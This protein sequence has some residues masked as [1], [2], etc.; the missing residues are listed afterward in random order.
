[1]ELFPPNKTSL[2]LPQAEISYIPNFLSK[3][4][5]DNLLELLI[6][7]TIW[8]SD[9]ITVFGKTHLQPRLTAYYTSNNTPY[10]YS[11]ITMES[12]P[13]PDYLEQIKQKIEQASNEKF[14][15]VLLNLYRNGQDSNGWHAD[16]EK[17]LGI[18]PTIAS[19]SLGAERYFH[20]KHRTIK[21]E[22]HKINLQHDSLLI[23]KG[24]MQHHWL[25]QI[26]KTKIHKEARINLTFRYINEKTEIPQSRFS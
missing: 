22:R 6:K 21:S 13:I 20:F 23:M 17:S 7:N 4:F 9:K 14:N 12:K 8:Q 24:E 2:D 16:N 26:P 19:L 5:A 15:A 1:M 3:P 18:N 10:S 25:H 11:N